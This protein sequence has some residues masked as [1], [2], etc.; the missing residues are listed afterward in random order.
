VQ[1]VTEVRMLFWAEVVAQLGEQEG[2]HY[3]WDPI[4]AFS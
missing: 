1:A 4:Q 2:S 3:L